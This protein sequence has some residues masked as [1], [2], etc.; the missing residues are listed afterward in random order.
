[1]HCN[2]T[3]RLLAS[4][5]GSVRYQPTAKSVTTELQRLVAA[6]FHTIN[7]SHTRSSQRTTN[8]GPY[9]SSAVC[10]TRAKFGPSNRVPH[11]N[12][13]L[14]SY[15]LVGSMDILRITGD[16]PAHNKLSLVEAIASGHSV[17]MPEVACLCRNLVLLDISPIFKIPLTCIAGVPAQHLPRGCSQLFF[18]RLSVCLWKAPRIS[19]V[20]TRGAQW[21][22]ALGC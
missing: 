3:P 19:L 20:D 5:Y 4:T 7:K 10:C 13:N 1:M 11:C 9:L 16:V 21:N 18:S 15:R 6:T 12:S 17:D 14:L 22:I 8:H 2:M